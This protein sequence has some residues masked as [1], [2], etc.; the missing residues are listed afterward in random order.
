MTI[1]RS[2]TRWHPGPYGLQELPESTWIGG[3]N[4][5]LYQE[6]D[7]GHVGQWTPCS[8]ARGRGPALDFMGRYLSFL[9]LGPRTSL[10]PSKNLQI[11]QVC[12]GQ[13][14]ANRSSISSRD[15]WPNYCTLFLLISGVLFPIFRSLCKIRLSLFQSLLILFFLCDLFT[16]F[17]LLLLSFVCYSCFSMPFHVI[18][19]ANNSKLAPSTSSLSAS[20]ALLLNWK[21]KQPPFTKKPYSISP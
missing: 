21:E 8:T 14:K 3:R 6:I 18:L 17:L 2:E 20:S 4:C 9:L 7:G 11:L 5:P 10:G 15:E 19:W 1:Y 12:I 16:T 13:L